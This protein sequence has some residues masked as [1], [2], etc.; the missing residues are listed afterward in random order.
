MH[1]YEAQLSPVGGGG[2]CILLLDEYAH[3]FLVGKPTSLLV[4]YWEFLAM[5]GT[6][7][8]LGLS[9]SSRDDM[10]AH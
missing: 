2:C 9:F 6:C 8:R 1:F 5:W 4:E 10:E 7:A 3:V